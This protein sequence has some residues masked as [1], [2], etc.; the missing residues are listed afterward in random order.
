MS[1]T[2]P[3]QKIQA[4]AWLLYLFTFGWSIAAVPV[5]VWPGTLPTGTMC[6]LL[7]VAF[8]GFAVPWWVRHAVRDIPDGEEER[9]W[10]E[11]VACYGGPLPN[12]RLT[13]V[14]H[15]KDG[16]TAVVVLDGT[17][18]DSESAV[19]AKKRIASIYA[20]KY[21]ARQAISIASVTLE[22]T[23][24]DRA[25][26]LKISIFKD[27]PTHEVMLYSDELYELAEGCVPVCRFPDRKHGFFRV[28]MPKS[29]AYPFLIAGDMG[30]GKSR[31]TDLVLTQSNRTGLVHT[32]FIDP[33]G[34]ASSAAW[35]GEEG[36]SKWIGRNR[37][38]ALSMLR[39]VERI[40]YAR[41]EANS[42]T[43]WHDKKGRRH[44]GVDYFEPTRERPILQVVIEEAPALLRDPE[45]KRI[46][47][48]IAR[49]ARKCGIQLGLICQW[50][51][52]ESLG[53]SDDL[54]T[55]LS[56][57]TII[58]MR[59]GKDIGGD[60]LLPPH[61]AR[62]ANPAKMPKSYNGKSSAGTLVLD[63]SAPGSSRGVYGRAYLLEDEEGESTS[64]EWAEIASAMSPELEEEAQVA[65]G[66]EY[67]HFRIHGTWPDSRP[68]PSMAK[69]S[70]TPTP[71]GPAGTEVAPQASARELIVDLFEDRDRVL[72]LSAD[73]V[74]S[75]GMVA[76]SLGLGQ[77]R[78]TV[79]NALNRLVEEGY[80]AKNE[81]NRYA[82]AVQT[83]G[84]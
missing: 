46:I 51:G 84:I 6:I 66:Q 10:E 71:S 53:G 40:M 64:D 58:S 11:F 74:L 14:K 38:Q 49:M 36:K 82:R 25:D 21:G 76:E 80:I 5:G 72:A 8:L 60:I 39:A 18:I 83:V 17:L 43:V 81:A 56:A 3:S 69:P 19:A 78:N 23:D 68:G 13:E 70:P 67:L 16:W 59:I 29:G 48:E 42:K 9:I 57:G 22:S 37:A 73:G 63:S 52:L 44:I 28:W 24:D 54:R 34:G 20:S 30:S 26:L 62:T 4:Y 2:K 1:R 27:N 61:I 41:A 7:F 31:V 65:A 35:A 77:Q 33:Q 32:W 50:P 79:W 55:Q 75:L 15:T 45:M 12:S 47:L